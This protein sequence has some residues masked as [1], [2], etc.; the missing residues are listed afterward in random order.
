MKHMVIPAILEFNQE[1]FKVRLEQCGRMV[2]LQTIQVDFTD[3]LFVR[4][5][6][7]SVADLPPLDPKFVWEAHLMIESPTNFFDY[8]EAGFSK[9]IVHYEAY[10]TESDLRQAIQAI[11]DVKCTPAVAINP[12]TTA[13]VLRNLVDDVTNFTLLSVEPGKQGG[14]F[15]PAVYDRVRQVRGMSS[16][17]V[18]EVDGGLNVNNISLLADA[19]AQELVVG[20]AIFGG[21]DPAE[22]FHRLQRAI[23]V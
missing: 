9:I 8:H 17:A 22:N 13:L 3:G 12:E 19:G 23:L 11:R 6:T 18:V 7:L 16:N 5:R 10:G 1:A 2:D 20:S 21:G 4:G 15:M 14:S